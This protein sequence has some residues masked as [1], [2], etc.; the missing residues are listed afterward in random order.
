ML[1]TAELA[2]YGPL[3]APTARRLAALAPTWHRLFTDCTTGQALGVGRTALPSTEGA[4]P[5]PAFPRRD[6]PVPGLHPPGRSLRTRPHHRVAGRWNH[7]RRQ[8][9]DALPESTTH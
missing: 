1:A 6:L 3:D 7:R 4:A 9:G 2:G 5:V 8:P